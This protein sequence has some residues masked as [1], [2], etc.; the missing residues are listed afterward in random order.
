MLDLV[1]NPIILIMAFALYILL[2]SPLDQFCRPLHQLAPMNQSP[3]IQKPLIDLFVNL[4]AKEMSCPNVISLLRFYKLGMLFS[5]DLLLLSEYFPPSVF[6]H[7]H[8]AI[9]GIKRFFYLLRLDKLLCMILT[10]QSF[11]ILVILLPNMS[12]LQITVNIFL[13][14][15]TILWSEDFRLLLKFYL[16]DVFHELCHLLLIL[17]QETEVIFQFLLMLNQ[18]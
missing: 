7:L 3:M 16:M 8:I 11:S 6:Y 14:I 13:G 15:L 12:Q 9:L 2:E 5:L 10:N 17:H 18:L 1:Q 4:L